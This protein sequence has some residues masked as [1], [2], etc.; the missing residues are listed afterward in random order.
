MAT[1]SN[2][3]V[4]GSP[5]KSI[6]Q[7]ISSG[8]NGNLSFV[9]SHVGKVQFR[10]NKRALKIEAGYSGSS[11]PSSGSIFVG[12]FI[13]GGMVVGALGCI[14]APQITEALSKT[15][16]KEI[17]KKLPK[18]IY[19][20]EKDMEKKRKIIEDKIASLNAAID[21]AASHFSG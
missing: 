12:G 10:T 7:S 3:F 15:D 5:L 4:S 11:R 21:E 16:K 14:Y 1:L 13:L 17:M 9:P 18:F 2:S 8:G 19:D 20:E 6:D